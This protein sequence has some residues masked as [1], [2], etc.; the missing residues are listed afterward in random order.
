MSWSNRSGS[1]LL[2]HDSLHRR[3]VQRAGVRLLLLHIPKL[4][5]NSSHIQLFRRQHSTS[6]GVLVLKYSNHAPWAVPIAPQLI[7]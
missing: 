6:S 4:L 5:H 7:D 3:I 2:R 1:R